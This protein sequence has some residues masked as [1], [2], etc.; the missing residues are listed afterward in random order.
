MPKILIIDDE[1]IFRKG[2]RSMISAWDM[3]WEIVGD[4]R[5]GYEA[6][7]LV[8]S[9]RPDAILTDIRMPR[10]DG[11]QLQQICH[12]RYPHLAC[13]VI[14]G[15]EDFTY[16][17]QSLRHGAKDF[18]LKPV[19][20]EELGGV[21]DK[22]KQD[23]QSR[24]S[25]APLTGARKEEQLI[26][27]HVEEHLIAGLLQGSVSTEDMKL[28]RKIGIQFDRPYFACMVIKLD[29]QSVDKERYTKANPT[30]FQLYIQQFVQ[31]ILDHRMSGFS[32]MHSESEVVAL[33][34]LKDNSASQLHLMETAASIRRQIQS[35]SK[36]TVTIGVGT[37]VE[38][39]RSIPKSYNEA[40]IALLYRLI[41]GGDKVLQYEQTAR[42]NQFKSGMKKW[43]WELLEKS[44]N[45]G[46]RVEVD[47]RVEEVITDLCR[48]APNPEAVHQ[49]IC[50][51]LIHYYELAENLDITNRWLGPKDIRALLVDVCSISSIEELVDKCRE[52]LGRLAECIASSDKPVQNNPIE[53]SLKYLERHFHE[54]LNLKEMADKV[55]LN[56]AYFSTLFKQKTGKTFIEKLTELRIQEAKKKLALTEEKISAISE[57][58]GFV[59]IR[60]FNR[61]FK[62]ETGMTPKDYRERTRHK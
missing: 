41:A 46:R 4:A 38:G 55:F 39:V 19:E 42:E 28:L 53:Q 51:L 5:D 26:R 61:V 29:K 6:L 58:T 54:P 27:Q 50:K 15:Y 24:S 57:D 11:L 10:M 7:D 3:D 32:F 16:V 22:L 18:L 25:A 59:N 20:R 49:Q 43:S 48:I 35:L 17:Q 30:L 36:L 62:H 14:S 12:D 21:L 33:I 60:H 37:I 34:N 44:I 13:V 9:L 23:M 2:L 56:P 47:S 40:G 31:E 52:L 45:N 8:E 1:T